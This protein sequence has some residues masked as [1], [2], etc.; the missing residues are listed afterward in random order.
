MRISKQVSG[1]A[2]QRDVASTQGRGEYEWCD[3]TPYD[4]TR[5]AL[6]DRRIWLSLPGDIRIDTASVLGEQGGK[7]RVRLADPHGRYLYP[8]YHLSD[9]L[10]MPTTTRQEQNWGQGRPL[11]RNDQYSVVHIHCGRV[12]TSGA[13][14]V[15]VEVERLTVQNQFGAEDLDFNQRFQQVQQVWRERAQLDPELSAVIS[16]H[17]QIVTQGHDVSRLGG[18]LVEQIQ[19]LTA[20]LSAE[21]SGVRASSATGDP[22]PTLLQMLGL[23]GAVVAT[24][25]EEIPIDLTEVRRREIRNQRLVAARGASAARF[26]RDVR[27]AYDST[28]FVCGLRL[29]ACVPGG[30][31]GVD[32]S[33]ILPYSQ[34]NLDDVRNGMC[35]CKLHHWAFDEGLIEIHFDGTNYRV[36]ITE[37]AQR[38]ADT[39]GLT[40]GWLIAQGGAIP[41]DRPP[42]PAS[43]PD[44]ALLAHLRTLLQLPG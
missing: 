26:R 29:P 20:E 6:L 37:E 13:D 14:V 31:P 43:R 40:P 2:D 36:V 9:A 21:M 4:P 17:E 11:L 33:H 23:A 28:C 34:Y 16:Q 18:P 3:F 35:L 22:L 27:Q 5:D 39:A 42:P 10:L 7:N 38:L 15:F 25:V 44:P 8:H 12:T 32:S 24:P 41:P 30:D 19:R 1:N